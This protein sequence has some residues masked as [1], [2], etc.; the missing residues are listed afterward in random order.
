MLL[1]GNLFLLVMP[2]Q[3]NQ[4][5]LVM[6]VQVKL[7]L[8]KL[9][10]AVNPFLPVMFV[11]VNLFLL[12]MSVQVNMFLPLMFVPVK[13]FLAATSVHINLL[14]V[15]F[16][17]YQYF[18]TVL[19]VVY[20][21]YCYRVL[22]L[23]Q[24]K[25]VAVKYFICKSNRKYTYDFFKISVNR[26]GHF[27]KIPHDFFKTPQPCDNLWLIEKKI[28]WSKQNEYSSKQKKK[29]KKILVFLWGLLH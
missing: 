19:E 25:V 3:V 14:Q 10:V 21:F 1:P 13:L 22:C 12:E 20:C 24:W 15:F 18:L 11:L 8:P 4:F 16:Q 23:C 2:V 6:S 17:Q 29:K 28:F 27:S 5:L 9:F 7:F 26:M